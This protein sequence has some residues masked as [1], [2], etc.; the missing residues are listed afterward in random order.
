MSVRENYKDWVEIFEKS[1]GVNFDEFMM[2]KKRWRN[3]PHSE[4]I[5][6]MKIKKRNR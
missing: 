3:L 6:L 5:R 2:L 4:I 1:T